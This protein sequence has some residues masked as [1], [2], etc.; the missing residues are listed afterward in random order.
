M[1][2][3]IVALSTAGAPLSFGTKSLNAFFKQRQMPTYEAHV[4]CGFWGDVAPDRTARVPRLDQNP[5]GTPR[6][7]RRHIRRLS[8]LE[9]GAQCRLIRGT[10]PHQARAAAFRQAGQGGV[11]VVLHA[12]AA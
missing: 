2:L 1:A 3:S 6:V 5:P 12:H 10:R 11:F 8:V 7:V 4:S 9:R